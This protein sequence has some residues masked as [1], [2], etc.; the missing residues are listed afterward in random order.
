MYSC[1]ISCYCEI[2]LSTLIIYFSTYN[3]NQININIQ[4]NLLFVNLYTYRFYFHVHSQNHI[5]PVQTDEVNYLLVP[6]L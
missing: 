4:Y 2:S 3:K 5:V 6:Y 1:T